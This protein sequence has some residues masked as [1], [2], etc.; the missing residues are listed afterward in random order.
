MVNLKLYHGS[1]KKLEIMEP[2]QGKGLN[3]FQN[4]KAVFL[5]SSYKE[6]CLYALGKSLK[7]KTSFGINKKNLV[8]K[9][10]MQPDEEGF[11]YEFDIPKEKAIAGTEKEN[12]GIYAILEPIIPIKTH[13]IKLKDFK[14]YIIYVKTKEELIEKLYS[15]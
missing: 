5:T 10:N 2:R 12:L 15:E 11:V 9:G 14:K 6:A 7:G 8:I 3:A 1:S 4:L 13:K